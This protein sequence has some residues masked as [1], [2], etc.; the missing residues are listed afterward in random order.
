MTPTPLRTRPS[1]RAHSVLVDGIANWQSPDRQ[2][3]ITDL[4][5]VRVLSEFS[6]ALLDAVEGTLQAPDLALAVRRPGV[7]APKRLHDLAEAEPDRLQSLGEE[8]P[9]RDSLGMVVVPGFG[10]GA[11]GRTPDRS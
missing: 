5:A 2:A 4:R 9:L 11:G 10:A 7:V 6:D 3:L 1:G 8:D